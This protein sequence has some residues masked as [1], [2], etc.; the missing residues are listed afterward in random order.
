[1]NNMDTSS[2]IGR[3]QLDSYQQNPPI[4]LGLAF[5]ASSLVH[6]S[7]IA[8]VITTNNGLEQA[9]TN[10]PQI[11]ITIVTADPSADKKQKKTSTEKRGHQSAKKIESEE[12]KPAKKSNKRVILATKTTK[13]V[14]VSFNLKRKKYSAKQ[15]LR[16]KKT[17]G[18]V[19]NNTTYRKKSTPGGSRPPQYK[20]GSANSPRPPY[21]YLA[22]KRGWEGRVILRVRVDKSGYP[23]KVTVQKSSGYHILDKNALVTVRKWKFTPSLR[24]GYRVDASITIPIRFEFSD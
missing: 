12:I 20:L 14:P 3:Y 18:K 9:V 23:L 2:N 6:F 5:I 10:Y 15:K 7:V 22:R 21:S 17:L 11:N 1:M 13:K 16:K 19:A 4:L 8:L 24:D